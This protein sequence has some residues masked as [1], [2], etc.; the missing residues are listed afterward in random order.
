MRSHQCFV[1]SQN[2][3]FIPTYI[4]S[5][6]HSKYSVF[7]CNFHALLVLDLFRDETAS[8]SLLQIHIPIIY[9]IAYHLKNNFIDLDFAIQM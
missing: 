6:Y 7:F 4:C 9:I 5:P 1:Q 2:Y 8:E 3:I